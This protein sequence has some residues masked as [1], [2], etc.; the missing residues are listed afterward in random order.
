MGEETTAQW[1]K[2]APGQT[3]NDMRPLKEA[4]HGPEV[5][6]LRSNDIS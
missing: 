3:G 2:Q 4:W 5:L 6:Q 1:G